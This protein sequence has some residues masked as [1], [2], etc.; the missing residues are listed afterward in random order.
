[1][2]T[3]LDIVGR[4]ALLV[5]GRF[6]LAAAKVHVAQWTFA[7][8]GEQ[9][10]VGGTV[11]AAM[12]AALC[13]FRTREGLTL[14]T[15][16][17]LAGTR[18]FSM[19]LLVIMT[20]GVVCAINVTS[21]H[22][23]QLL[24][25]VDDSASMSLP[26]VGTETRLTRAQN[27]LYTRGFLEELRKKFTVRVEGTS[28]RG[29]VGEAGPANSEPPPAPP[30]QGGENGGGAQDLAKELVWHCSW[31]R[32]QPL[33]QVLLISDG[34]E[35]GTRELALA[36]NELPALVSTLCVG[37]ETEIHDVILES[38]AVPPYVYLHDHAVVSAQIQSIGL[39]HEVTVKLISITDAGE[40]EVGT[41]TVAVKPGADAAIAHIEFETKAAGFQHYSLRLQP[42]EGE[43]TQANNAIDFNL[44]VRSDKIKVL[45][46][47]GEP[48]WEYKFAKQ[49]LESDPVID[50]SGLVRLPGDEWFYQGKPARPDSKPVFANPKD[51]FPASSDELDYFD[52]LILGDV[53]RKI[54]EQ[55]G[56]FDVLESFVTRR[57]GGLVTIGGY[58]VYAAGNYEDTPLAR[59]VPFQITRDKKLQLIN[60]FNVQATTQAIMHPAM[61]LEQ[62]P[63]KNVEAWAKLPWVEGGNAFKAVKPGA[64]TLLVHPT[65]KTTLGP[66]PIAAAWQVGHGRVFSSALDGT[67]HWRLARTTENDYHKRFWG[68]VSRWSAGDPRTNKR[69]GTLVCEDPILEVAKPATFSVTIKDKDGNP[70]TSAL[71][72]FSVEQ[73]ASDPINGQS[74]SDAALPGR[75]SFTYVPAKSGAHH[76]KATLVIQGEEPRTLEATVYV[77]PA[78]S[79]FLR[80]T[81]DAQALAA[82][83][84]ATGGTS[85]SLSKYASFT[86]P[87]SPVSERVTQIT[88]DLWH[89]P[90]L[91]ML[92]VL[93]LSVEWLMRKRRGLA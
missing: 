25:L 21:A 3:L 89:A 53:E 7:P 47:E 86:L 2:Q 67:W 51:G 28:G 72:R 91:M 76:V 37:D 92:M 57:G 58:K 80:V 49:S 45:F 16:L 59:M 10:L 93:S 31:R 15:R 1:M 79:E 50:F 78:R 33:E 81:P 68:Q 83:A 46:V 66:R 34:I 54:F 88:I 35:T 24:V 22:L 82:L 90:G 74:V 14:R 6:D 85:G 38:A 17:L 9:L 40:K 71:T 41:T 55:S 84:K 73:P 18:F 48:S 19:L 64:T 20:S 11:M 8:Y 87:E 69:I 56:R 39:E 43:L 44:D 63:K 75:Y 23:P 26:V 30:F 27:V 70:D 4:L 42:L 77:A 13:Y 36:A 62:D 52:V 61:Q 12:L 32:A 29:P 5:Q 60:R 65:L